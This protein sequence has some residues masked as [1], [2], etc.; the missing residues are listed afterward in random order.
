MV[1]LPVII[2]CTDEATPLY[3]SFANTDDGSCNDVVYG[4]IYISSL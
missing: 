2:G 1:C 4:C 3:N